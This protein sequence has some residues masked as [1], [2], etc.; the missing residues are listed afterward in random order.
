M[1]MKQQRL[2][3]IAEIVQKCIKRITRFTVVDM[4]VR[5]FGQVDTALTD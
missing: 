2:V 4:I 3:Q 5:L 1:L